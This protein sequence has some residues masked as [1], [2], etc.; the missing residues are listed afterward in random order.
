MKHRGMAPTKAVHHEAGPR[1]VK[2][3]WADVARVEVEVTK[4]REVVERPK[5]PKLW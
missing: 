1:P 4:S 2:A 5:G 3:V